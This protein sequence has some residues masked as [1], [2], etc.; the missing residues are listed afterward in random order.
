MNDYLSI[1]T[2]EAPLDRHGLRRLA[3][4]ACLD[5]HQV[6]WLRCYLAG[7]G[8]RM[9]CWYQARDAE[10]VRLVLRQ[11]GSPEA[12]VWP[13]AATDIAGNELLDASIGCLVM[14]L[15]LNSADTDEAAAATAA[16]NAALQGSGAVLRRTFLI[17]HDA[18]LMGVVESSNPV[19]VVERLAA[20]GIRT[21]S[22]WECTAF[23]P[24]PS[25]LFESQA[26]STLGGLDGHAE[27]R[28]VAAADAGSDELDAI[29]IGAGLSGMSALER[30]IRMGM[31]V[32]VFE[33]GSDVGG[34]WYWNRYPGARVDSEVHTYGFAF[35]EALVRDWNWQELFAAQPEISSYL[36]HVADR[37]DLRQHIRFGTRVVSAVYDDHSASWTIETDAGERAN[38]RFLILAAGTLSA[39]QLPDY[40]GIE[41]FAGRS[42]HTADW[43]ADGIDLSGKRVGVIGTGASGVQVIQTIAADVDHLT[44]LQRTPTYCVPQRN[45]P[46][47]PVDRRRIR[48]DWGQILQICRKSYGGFIHTF[49]P[50]SGLSVSVAE[51]EAKFEELWQRSGFAFWFGNFADLMMNSEVNAHACEFLKNKIKARVHDPQTA[52]MLLPDHPFGAKRVP[53]ECGYY[54]TYNRSNVTLVDLRETP[55]D[56]ITA[57]GIQT[58]RQEHLL[59]VIIYAT[60][61]DAGTGSIDR[62]DIRGAGGQQLIEK[63]QDGAQTFLGLLVGGFPNLFIVNGPHNAAAL[64]NAGRCIEQNVDWIARC[65][66]QMRSRGALRVVP[67]LAAEAEWTQHVEDVAEASV[68]AGM[69]N[70]WFFGANT[71]GKPRRVT[72][73]AAGASEYRKHCETV[74]I[75]GFTGLEFS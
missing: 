74:A 36:Q 44:V 9:L 72:I 22:L 57:S 28:G 26:P 42:C 52:R 45:H 32:R 5:L 61:F 71:P 66:E 41:A 24:E 19:T 38:A 8:T 30:F 56:R 54:E 75:A 4:H 62:I 59:D 25:K 49:D 73:Y 65:I 40:P 12:S 1:L 43:P 7:D 46:L 29:V 31:R 58:S 13:V 27:H 48:E 18:R 16:V 69:K 20:A 34:V 35:S 37:F 63:W 68:L 14:D 60:G 2:L 70:S 53:L 39:P 15:P 51:R 67:T 55:I 64:C 33:S 6:G 23:D 3:I 11:Q 47:T 50:R 21:T 10:S 17:E